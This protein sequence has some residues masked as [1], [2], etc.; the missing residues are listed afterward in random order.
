MSLN[1]ILQFLVPK[2]KKFFPLFHKQANVLVEMAT[3]LHEAVNLKEASEREGLFQKL[4]KLEEKSEEITRAINFELSKNF[5]TP[6]DRE[7][8]YALASKM[9]EVTDFIDASAS[10]MKLYQ[11]EKVKKSIRK[12]TEANFEACQNIQKAIEALEGFKDMKTVLKCCEKIN[13]L[14]NK[15]DNIYDKEIYE[16]FDE[17]ENVKDIIKYK[18]VFSALENTTDKCKYVADVLEAISLKHS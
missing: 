7:D 11:V 12:I 17:Y 8:I 14:E 6:F 10:R 18:E 15:V 13:K 3:I 9:N 16:I 2:D 1:S 5:L 4:G